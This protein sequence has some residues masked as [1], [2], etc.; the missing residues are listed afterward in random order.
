M[1]LRRP[2]GPARHARRATP[3]CRGGASSLL[4]LTPRVAAPGRGR[5]GLAHWW[6]HAA[7]RLLPHFAAADPEPSQGL[8]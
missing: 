3:R 7:S 5:L 2:I 6:A 1:P 4:R 8:A